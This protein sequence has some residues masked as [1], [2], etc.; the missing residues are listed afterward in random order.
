MIIDAH[1]H[2]PVGEELNSLQK[3]KEHLLQEM[4]KNNVSKCIVISDSELE[5]TIGS[6]EECVTLLAE[7]KSIYVVAGISPDICFEEQLKKLQEYLEKMQV[8]GIKLFTGHEAFYL[9]DERLE[10]VYETAIQYDVP[11]LFHSGWENSQYG[12]VL[13]AVQVAKKYPKLKLVCCHCFYPDISK[14]RLLYDFPNVFFDLSS[15]ADDALIREHIMGEIR[16]LI[17]AVPERVV[18][19]S[20][21]SACSQAEHI[22]FI[23][24]L[25]LNKKVEEAVL[26]KNAIDIYKIS[27]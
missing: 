8:V 13:Y 1:V 18:W 6:M 3:Q 11:V 2:L 15:V 4:K 26:Y 10:T 21:Y 7:E 14:C 16:N 19:G 27:M 22:D 25:G 20:D 12:D 23:K 24:E 9:T 5:S 17:N